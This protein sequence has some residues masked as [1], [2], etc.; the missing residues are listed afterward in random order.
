MLLLVSTCSCRC[1]RSS[2]YGKRVLTC[3]EAT[4][5][6]VLRRS[7]WDEE[8]E[9]QFPG[10]QITGKLQEDTSCFIRPASSSLTLNQSQ[11]GWS[12][13]PR[14]QEMGADVNDAPSHKTVDVIGSD[15]ITTGTSSPTR[16]EGDVTTAFQRDSGTRFRL[17]RPLAFPARPPP[18]TSLFPSHGCAP[19]KCP[20][21][22]PW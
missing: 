15:R 11:Y 12:R 19:R 7:S 9:F 10:A 6:R 18:G 4:A 17:L 20:V 16:W 8:P 2:R 13:L 21:C 14:K 1:D 3:D 5:I 22:L